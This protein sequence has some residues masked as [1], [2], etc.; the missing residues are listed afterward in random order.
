LP[1]TSGIEVRARPRASGG[2]TP[3]V[4]VTAF[5]ALSRHFTQLRLA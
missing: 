4:V 3:I 5:P 1:D 2:S